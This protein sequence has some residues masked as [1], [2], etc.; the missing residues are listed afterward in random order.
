MSGAV[1]VSGVAPWCAVVILV[2]STL[3]AI[4]ILARFYQYAEVQRPALLAAPVATAGAV[5][6]VLVVL[7]PY[8]LA[9]PPIDDRFLAAALGEIAPKWLWPA[10]IAVVSWV[11]V[12]AYAVWTA[13]LFHIQQGLASNTDRRELRAAHG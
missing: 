3:S 7:V 2:L 4:A 10:T 12:F 13:R 5:L 1:F 9:S 6:A 8:L 11:W